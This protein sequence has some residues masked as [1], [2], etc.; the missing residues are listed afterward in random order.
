MISSRLDVFQFMKNLERTKA[1][2]LSTLTEGIHIHS[3][4]V[5]NEKILEN[6]KEALKKKNYLIDL[7]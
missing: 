7:E 3:I 2:P 6:I 1:E 4:E 5:E